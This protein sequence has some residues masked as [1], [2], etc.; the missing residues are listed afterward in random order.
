MNRKVFWRAV[1]RGL[2]KLNNGA[3]K[4]VYIVK[5][6]TQLQPQARPA[7]PDERAL[8]GVPPH[9][10]RHHHLLRHDAHGDQLEDHHWGED[11]VFLP[12]VVL[13][14]LVVVIITMMMVKIDR[15]IDQGIITNLQWF[16]DLTGMRPMILM[17]RITFFIMT[18]YPQWHAGNVACKV[19][20]MIRTGGYILS[21]LM[22]I[23]LSVDR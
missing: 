13:D 9:H 7:Q 15:K 6:P 14:L 18:I 16:D 21:S 3:S 11:G 19:L 23:V 4:K 2:A 5:D 20:M 10:R 17:I 22:L 8:S 12:P 1:A